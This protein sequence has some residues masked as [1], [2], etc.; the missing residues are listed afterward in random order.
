MSHD[1]EFSFPL[2]LHQNS[3]L[4]FS[5]AGLVVVKMI[6]L[7]QG[8]ADTRGARDKRRRRTSSKLRPLVSGTRKKKAI[9]RGTP[10]PKKTKPTLAPRF[11]ASGLIM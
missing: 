4:E 5:W 1:F 11:P 6:D 10:R 3:L 7:V 2:A 9:L 8:L